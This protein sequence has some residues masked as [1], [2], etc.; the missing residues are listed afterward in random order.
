MI[1]TD[2]LI[3]GAGP[4]GSTL[5]KYLAISNVDNILIQRNFNFRKPCGG[6]VR[7]DAFDEFKIDK[8]L[9]KKYV[10]HIS[11]VTK[12]KRIEVDISKTPIAI[13]DRVEFDSSLRVQAE[14][15]GS[16]VMQASFVKV[17]VFQDYVVST[18]KQEDNYIKIKS[19][20]L[21]AA[22]GVNSKIRK[23]INGDTVCSGLT[24][25]ADITSK[26]Y[27]S[28]EI[29]FGSD[30]SSIYYAWAFPHTHGSN[31]GT[32]AEDNKYMDNFMKH[33]EIDEDVRKLGYKIPHFKNN[34]F[35]KDRVFFVGDSA[36]QVLPFT[37]EGIYYAMSSAKILSDVL[38]QKSEPSEYEK[39]WNQKYLKKFSTLLKLQ[40]IFL[41]ND[42][43]ISIMMRLYRNKYIQKQLV[44]FW[45]G[46]REVE[47]NFMFF[48][49]TI[50]RVLK[51]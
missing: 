37:Y 32:S 19:N 24:S 6:G 27:E 40:T 25:Y 18:I 51:K 50:K 33:L 38:I 14:N 8:K 35:Y 7:V 28:C 3:V 21:V 1:E 17:E 45:L 9:I 41:K 39:K 23:M 29:H 49:R 42:F 34:I 16:K 46:N 4:A 20:Y 10:N 31:I 2:I 5:A 47:I 44:E 15:N 48:M 43:M 30:I 22:D 12:R 26:H 36:S 13:V 11:L